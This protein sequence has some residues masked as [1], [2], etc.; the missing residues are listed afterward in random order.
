MLLPVLLAALVV[1]RGRWVYHAP[2]EDGGA[3]AA[4]SSLMALATQPQRDRRP[5]PP[6][7]PARADFVPF[8]QL[9]PLPAFTAP[10]PGTSNRTSYV[11]GATLTRDARLGS[12]LEDGEEEEKLMVDV[13]F[14]GVS[15]IVSGSIDPP[16]PLLPQQGGPSM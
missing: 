15:S 3:G 14:M 6:P 5:P 9:T 4:A 1:L 2:F 8:E 7:L 13:F 16:V 11:L 12:G 10:L